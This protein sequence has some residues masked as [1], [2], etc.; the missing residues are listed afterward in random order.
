MESSRMCPVC[1]ATI[2]GRSDKKFC[3]AKCRSINQYENRQKSEAFYFK[4][5]RQ[6]KINRKLLKKYNRS[7]YTT[8]RK[9]VLI[10]EGFDPK[11]FTHYWKNKKGD[12]YLFVYEYGFLRK[13]DR[14]K[15][16]YVLVLWQDYMERN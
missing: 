4:V 16:K 5:D 15:E 12:I 14:G 10:E 3:S 8:I 1:G 2:K 11:F 7:G 9:T 6:L 13:V